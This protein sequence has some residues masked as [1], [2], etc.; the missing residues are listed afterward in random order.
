MAAP[1]FDG[2]EKEERLL[3]KLNQLVGIVNNL[4]AVGVTGYIDS[5][6]GSGVYG[7]LSG[8]VDG[9]NRIFTVSTGS[10]ISGSLKVYW[11]GQLQPGT[12]IT[13]TDPVGGMFKLGFTP[14]S[15]SIVMVE[16]L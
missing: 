1:S 7:Q 13:E 3:N 12:M 10:Y 5:S 4:V 8:A 14:K 15:G 9:T 16:Y 11:Q 2:S 6:D